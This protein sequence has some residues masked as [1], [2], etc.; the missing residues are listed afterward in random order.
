MTKSSQKFKNDYVSE[1]L[2]AG[3]TAPVQGLP[4]KDLGNQAS[5]VHLLDTGYTKFV[6]DGDPTEYQFNKELGI[7]TSWPNADA[8]N[9]LSVETLKDYKGVPKQGLFGMFGEPKTEGVSLGYTM[10]P[11]ELQRHQ[12][13]FKT[14]IQ[15]G[16]AF[17][18]GQKHHDIYDGKETTHH[19]HHGTDFKH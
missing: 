3:A 18:M 13:D 2:S 1:L 8:A 16:A 14:R 12:R 11:S 10:K 15:L 19:I 4:E 17:P 5:I 7:G 6:N 9:P